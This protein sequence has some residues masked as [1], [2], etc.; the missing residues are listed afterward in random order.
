[1]V[2]YRDYREVLSRLRSLQTL[3]REKVLRAPGRCTGSCMELP[4]SGSGT[5]GLGRRG[6][7]AIVPS[8]HEESAFRQP[9]KSKSLPGSLY[10]RPERDEHNIEF[11]GESLDSRQQPF[12][13]EGR[14]EVLFRL[15]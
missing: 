4:A 1:M 14:D 7:Q 2:S 13:S 11:G 8:A 15:A 3:H 12:S 5:E 6:D 9:A 10:D